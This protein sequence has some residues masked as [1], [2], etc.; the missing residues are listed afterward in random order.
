MVLTKTFLPAVIALSI[1][2]PSALDAQDA[3]V[4]TASQETATK[5]DDG[6]RTM[7][8]FFPNLGRDI[9]FVFSTDNLKPFLAGAALT[10]GSAAFDDRVQRYFGGPVRRAQWWGDTA[11]VMDRAYVVV[12]TTLA[13]FALGRVT[14]HSHQRFKDMTYDFAEATVVNALYTGALKYAVQ[15]E[16][17]NGLNHYSFPSGHASDYFTWA[18]V[19]GHHYGP[20][21]G[22]PAFV[23]ASL[24][25]LGRLE[26]NEHYLSDV[27]GGATL[28]YLVGRTVVREDSRPLGAAK[29]VHVSIGPEA[30]ARLG[31]RLFLA[32]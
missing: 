15:R 6:R 27:V 28:G 19:L 10:A 4:A 25:G 31:G 18:T 9:V 7:G 13:L 21:A 5:P 26:K 17:P 22:V 24:V 23:L 11:D 3:S 20:K 2:G 12:P 16:R 30:R 14:P 8:R 32:F 29:T 1:V